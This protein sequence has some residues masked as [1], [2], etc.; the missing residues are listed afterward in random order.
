MNEVV[1]DLAVRI[2]RRRPETDSRRKC[3]RRAWKR[4]GA[5]YSRLCA[6]D[7]RHSARDSAQPHEFN[8]RFHT[9]SSEVLKAVGQIADTISDFRDGTDQRF[10][11]FE[12]PAG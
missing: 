11:K 3:S 2:E 5:G 1:S 10:A 9:M 7:P 6:H 8:V 4:K 12:K